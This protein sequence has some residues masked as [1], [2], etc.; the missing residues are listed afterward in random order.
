M[1]FCHWHLH[2][3]YFNFIL[4]IKL[5]HIQQY[6]GLLIYHNNSRMS[7]GMMLIMDGEMLTHLLNG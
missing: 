7:Y 1:I 2:K 6:L 3:L 4:M 5:L